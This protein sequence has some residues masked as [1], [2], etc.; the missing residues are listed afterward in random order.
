MLGFLGVSSSFVWGLLSN[1]EVIFVWLEICR[2][3][4][5]LIIIFTTSFKIH[6]MEGRQYEPG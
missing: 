3:L 2:E 5:E 6:L 1:V 4:E